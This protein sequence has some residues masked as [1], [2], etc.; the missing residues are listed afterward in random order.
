MEKNTKEKSYITESLGCTPETNSF[1]N[2]LYFNAKKE[3]E[4]EDQGAF[5]PRRALQGPAGVQSPLFFD[6]PQS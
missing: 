2:Q 4:I 6:T 5:A 1:V 3:R